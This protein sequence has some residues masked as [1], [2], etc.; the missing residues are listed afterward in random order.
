M[1]KQYVLKNQHLLY[2]GN[3]HFTCHVSKLKDLKRLFKIENYDYK[4]PSVFI[5]PSTICEIYIIDNK[6]IMTTF[7]WDSLPEQD[8]KEFRAEWVTV[9]EYILFKESRIYSLN[10]ENKA[11][12][13]KL[14]AKEQT[15]MGLN[16]E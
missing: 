12:R 4:Y 14:A 7:P 13:I 15:T 2:Y 11:Y 9:K 16:R 3:W 6:V 8:C 1:E 10:K 5:E